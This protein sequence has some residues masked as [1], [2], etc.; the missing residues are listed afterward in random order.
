MKTICIIPARGGSKG[1]PKKNLKE[2]E[3][4][5]LLQHTIEFAK[6]ITYFSDI[7]ISSDCNEIN[8]FS[9]KFGV[10]VIRRPE[11]LAQ[12]TSLIIDALVYTVNEYERKKNV[13]VQYI[14]LLEP[15]SPI[16]FNRHI[17]EALKYLEEGYDS[18][19][20]F[21]ELDPPPTRIWNIVDD[22]VFPYL[23]ESN[24]FLPRQLQTK[25]YALTGQIYAFTKKLICED[26]N[27][28]VMGPNLKPIIVDEGAYIDIDTE[29]DFHIAQAK[30][31]YL[32]N[33]T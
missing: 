4:K 1:V 23:A 17:V 10:E 22:K 16:R 13:K 21:V 31:K 11:E 6:G 32:N 25:G 12:D 7:I 19:A 5:P 3:G 9:E 24:P 29:M 20:T 2:L 26:L 33:I 15:T 27:P 8:S 28:S 30:I 18:V 14:F